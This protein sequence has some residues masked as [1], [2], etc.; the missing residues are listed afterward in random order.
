M[1]WWQDFYAAHPAWVFGW[2]N[3]GSSVDL[4]D[5]N[6]TIIGNG[7]RYVLWSA[8]IH[9]NE[10]FTGPGIARACELVVADAEAG[11]YWSQRLQDITLIIVP[12]VNPDGYYSNIRE[13]RNGYNLNR[14]FP[15]GG[16]TTQPEAWAMRKLTALYKTDVNF[17]LHEGAAV[18]PNDWIYPGQMT[19][20]GLSVRTF[21]LAALAQAKAEFALLGHWGLYTDG[22]VNVDIGKIRNIEQSGIKSMFVS[23]SAYTYPAMSNLYEG[24]VGL[25]NA[26]AAR[27]MCYA[28]EY[29]THA[30]M[31]STEHLAKNLKPSFGFYFSA[32]VRRWP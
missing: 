22:G 24:I 29:Y 26:Y 20:S 7:S 25:S 16:T 6:Y 17:D 18:E 4:R 3:T 27:Q 5:I 32:K 23:W 15:P 19:D 10:K 28:T 1:T 12:I 14:E 31:L 9:G 8:C 13:N 2:N 11:G 21:T 30:L